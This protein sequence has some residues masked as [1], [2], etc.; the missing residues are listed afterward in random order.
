MYNDANGN[1][2]KF[3]D[4]ANAITNYTFDGLNRLKKLTPCWHRYIR[5]ALQHGWLS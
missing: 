4:H 5:L 3:I 2:T 1:R